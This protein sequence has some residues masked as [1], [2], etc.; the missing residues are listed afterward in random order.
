MIPSAISVVLI[1][2]VCPINPEHRHFNPKGE[3]MSTIRAIV[4]GRLAT[5]LIVADVNHLLSAPGEFASGR[6]LEITA[7]GSS[8]NI[9]EM[10]A[11]LIGP[12]RVAMLGKTCADRFGLWRVPIEA[13]V[14]AGVNVDYVKVLTPSTEQSF[15]G[16]AFIA[17]DRHGKNQGCLISG[18]SEEYFPSDV[19]EAL[20]LFHEISGRGFLVVS[21]EM[22]IATLIYALRR[23]KEFGIKTFI[24]ASGMTPDP[25]LTEA[26]KEQIY[27][28]KPNEH[29]TR[30]ITG[31][32]VRNLASARRAANYFFR[33]EVDNVLITAGA[34]GAYLITRSNAVHLPAPPSASQFVKDE[35]G[36]GD[37]TM[38]TLCSLLIEGADL[39]N[40]AEGAI[41]A[42][43]LQFSRKGVVPVTKAELTAANVFVKDRA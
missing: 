15:P 18:I 6:K 29:E 38:A 23:A 8:R 3:E 20:P 33:G 37:Q 34:A 7:G 12:Q 40:A 41:V 27:L 11:C 35:T 14:R 17:V 4:M 39:R 42:G 21:F 1:V 32:T 31:V 26:F 36:C 43:T 28:I 22:P 16:I 2:L 25:S 13:L 24:D 10:I 19:D 9:A 30:T 5:D